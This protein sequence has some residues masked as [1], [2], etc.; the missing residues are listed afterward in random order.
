MFS[1]SLTPR[2]AAHRSFAVALESR[3]TEPNAS[4]V[5]TMMLNRAISEWLKSD[6]KLSVFPIV[7]DRRIAI[8]PR[9]PYLPDSGRTVCT[10][11]HKRHDHLH[12]VCQR[13]PHRL[14]PANLIRVH[15]VVLESVLDRRIDLRRQLS[16]SREIYRLGF[17][18]TVSLTQFPNFPNPFFPPGKEPDIHTH[19]RR[20][21]PIPPSDRARLS[22]V[23]GSAPRHWLDGCLLDRW[24]H[25]LADGYQVQNSVAS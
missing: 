9:F 24:L 21:P 15:R 17:F 20:F 14:H 8:H 7:N 5:R 12:C 11:R 2:F 16:C 22:C 1:H 25:R 10:R 4:A 18:H 13:T 6:N 23:A 3:S 19:G